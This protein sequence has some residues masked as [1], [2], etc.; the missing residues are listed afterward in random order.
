MGIGRFGT[1]AG[2]LAAET[3][4]S[5]ETGGAFLPFEVL[6]AGVFGTMA[7]A[8]KIKGHKEEKHQRESDA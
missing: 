6:T 5:A 4:L 8:K 3:A 7:I 1:K 2:I